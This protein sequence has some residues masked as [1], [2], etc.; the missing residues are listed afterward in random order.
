MESKAVFF[1]AQMDHFVGSSCSPRLVVPGSS[2]DFFFYFLVLGMVIP[3]WI[4]NPYNGYISP[5]YWVDEFIPYYMEIIG[6]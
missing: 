5:Y 1:V 2:C 3:P 6:V 4:G